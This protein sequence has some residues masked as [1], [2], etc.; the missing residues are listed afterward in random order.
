MTISTPCRHLT[1]DER[2]QILTLYNAG[3]GNRQISRQLGISEA[4]IRR[5]IRSFNAASG[6]VPLTPTKSKGRRPFI[7]TPTR[8]RLILHAT[9]NAEQRRK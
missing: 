9:L 7:D 3:H 4:T 1:R 2:L 5:T 6:P 8:R